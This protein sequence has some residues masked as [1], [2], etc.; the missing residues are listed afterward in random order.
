MKNIQRL[1]ILGDFHLHPSDPSL[2]VAAMED[3]RSEN[4]DLVIALGDFGPTALIGKPEGIAV[5]WEHLS[6]IGAP[7]RPILGNH[8][9]QSES[10]QKL[11]P[12]TMERTL[13]EIAKLDTSY[14]ILEFETHRLL[15]VTT[16][17]QPEE[18]CWQVQECYASDQ[19]F[20]ALREALARRPGVPVVVF[21]HAPPIGSRLKTQPRTHPRATNAYLEQNHQPLRWREL[22]RNTPEIVLWFSAHYH[23]GHDHPDSHTEQFGTHFFHTQVHADFTRD[24]TRQTRLLEISNDY[25]A[26]AT[27]DHLERRK[28][29]TPDYE[30]KGGWRALM[31][32]KAKGGIPEDEGFSP[33]ALDHS[34]V[35][36]ILP[37]AGKRA[38]VYTEAHYLWE[39]DLPTGALMGAHHFG[40]ALDAIEISASN[41]W[42]A[43]GC[44][45]A[46]SNLSSLTRFM[47]FP[48]DQP[49]ARVGWTFSQPIQALLA[50]KNGSNGRV[51]VL[52]RQSLWEVDPSQSN[53]TLIFQSTTHELTRLSR[54]EDGYLVTTSLGL[55]LYSTDQ[56]ISQSRTANDPLRMG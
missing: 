17:Y 6:R 24:G 49:E 50:S 12:G 4:P 7:I 36:Q 56:A 23:L 11:Q 51:L 5:A 31:A 25:I 3:I 21:S 44:S 34:R 54:V 35:L 22:Y 41:A 10:A 32:A 13:C 45:L 48:D 30:W 33:I 2:T 26:V 37:I 55:I 43:W 9:L 29:S 20:N 27:I 28:R 8:D 39:A 16:E 52:T 42:R 38:L 47:R 46:V 40:C 15:F 19:Q 53:P 18:T 1:A 14:G